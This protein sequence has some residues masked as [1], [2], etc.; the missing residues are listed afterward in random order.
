MLA[1]AALLPGFIS[2]ANK[3]IFQNLDSNTMLNSNTTKIPI[4]E[5]YA[6]TNNKRTKN[7]KYPKTTT[8]PQA[9]STNAVK[10]AIT[11]LNEQCFNVTTDG[12]IEFSGFN[13]T[14]PHWQ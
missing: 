4:P 2:M 9:R 8:I 12:L 1:T 3:K 5:N 10:A 11:I 7:S 14:D 6:G 13:Y